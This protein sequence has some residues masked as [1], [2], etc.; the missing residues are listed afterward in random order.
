MHAKQAILEPGIGETVDVFFFAFFPFNWPSFGLNGP[1]LLV[2]YAGTTV[3]MSFSFYLCLFIDDT[4]TTRGGLEPID[5]IEIS[6]SNSVDCTR[7]H[8]SR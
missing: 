6:N 1:R 5:R 7:M 4:K 2:S 3:F 8:D